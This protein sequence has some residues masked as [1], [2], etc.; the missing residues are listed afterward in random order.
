MKIK[1]KED[2]IKIPVTFEDFLNEGNSAY[3]LGMYNVAVLHFHRAIELNTSDI[4]P[5]IGLAAAYRQK[6]MYFDSRRIL[7][8]AKK[9]FKRN[10]TVEVGLKF[11][12]ED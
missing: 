8:E 6:A 1:A 2:E 3:N 12:E 9:K 7:C 11:L 4:R 10:P 5:Y